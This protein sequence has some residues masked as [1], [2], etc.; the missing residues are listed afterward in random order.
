MSLSI[1]LY[2]TADKHFISSLVQYIHCYNLCLI[3]YNVN[4]KQ[5]RMSLHTTILTIQRTFG[6][7]IIM[8]SPPALFWLTNNIVPIWG[9]FWHTESVYFPHVQCHLHP[10][11]PK[12]N[13]SWLTPVPV[14][15]VCYY[16]DTLRYDLILSSERDEE[17]QEHWMWGWISF[18][19]L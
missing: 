5:H 11:P 6:N 12:K 18:W 8:L 19:Q 1:N 3:L 16:L 15:G 2:K 4:Y 13:M 7:H 14:E 17:K 10:P 9:L